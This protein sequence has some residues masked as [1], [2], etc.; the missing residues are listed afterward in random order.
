MISLYESARTETIDVC[1]EPLSLTFLHQT[2]GSG[3]PFVLLHGNPSHLGSWHATIPALRQLGAVCAID[4][5]GFGRSQTPGD[6]VLSL[7]RLADA[8]VAI[9]DFV[10]FKRFIPV[11][12]SFGGGVA[13]TIA[14]RHPDRVAAVILIAT[15]GTPANP[16][17]KRTQ[18]PFAEPISS[19]V[20]HTMLLGP[21]R[22]LARRWSV[23]NARM[24]CAPD[25]VPEG[26]AEADFEMVDRR[27]EIQGNS[28]RANI[29]DPTKQLVAQAA[30][31]R[32]PVLMVHPV[33]D[34]VVPMIYAE[35]L[36]EVLIAAGVKVTLKTV[37]GGHLTHLAHPAEVNAAVL[38]W[39]R[40]L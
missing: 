17:I 31:I 1:G 7:D 14:A 4:M 8:A 25:P 34:R 22:P 2:G 27:P 9:A 15:I 16:T 39:V 23:V 12:N 28:V 35:N 19:L 5:P 33:D 20:A 26:F 32:A 37:P 18:L 11:G 38:E 40:G 30:R 13:Q 21:L 6:R 3:D 10:G 24:N 36:R 29:C